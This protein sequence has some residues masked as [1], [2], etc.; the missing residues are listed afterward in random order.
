[1]ANITMKQLLEAGVHFGHRTRRWN[2][3]MRPYIFTERSG[4]HI[5]DLQQTLQALNNATDVVRN[6]V[7]KGGTVL[8]VGTKRQAQATIEQEALRCGM[9]YVNQRWL[10]G[11][12][13][14]WTT[15]RQRIAYLLQLERRIDA[16]EFNNLGKKER[17]GIQREVEKLNRRIGGLKTMRS[18][19]DLL[20]VVDTTVEELAVKEANKMRIPVIGMVDTNSDPE[21]VTYV[22]PTNDDAIRAIKLI[23]GAIADAAEEGMRIREVE[24]VETGQVSS[25]ELAE[26]EQYL[27]PSVLAKLK[28]L[29]DEEFEAY[30][31]SEEEYEEV[32]EEFEEELEDE[33]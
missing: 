19:P 18:L 10:G 13:T 25:E 24:M 26:M 30:E 8:F 4:I 3:K 12:L 29:D 23:V 22:I 11:T 5:I 21:P 16:G 15:I 6:T 28:S 1:M 33:E 7:A 17:L 32:G 9:P 27:G 14:N 20:F 2:P 31:E